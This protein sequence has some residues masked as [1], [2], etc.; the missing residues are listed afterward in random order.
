MQPTLQRSR[1]PRAIAARRAGLLDHVRAC[2]GLTTTQLA[3]A[4]GR[5]RNT[6]Q[7]DMD[8][9]AAAGLVTGW[10]QHV[11][12]LRRAVP[13]WF[14]SG[15]EPGDLDAVRR[16]QVQDYA[17]KAS[18]HTETPGST[19]RLPRNTACAG[20]DP[21]LFFP[22]CK[23]DEAAAK[24][25]CARCPVRADCF[26]GACARGEEYGVWGGENFERD[27]DLPGLP[28]GLGSRRASPARTGE[29]ALA[30]A[31]RIAGLHARHRS[32]S[33][34]AQAAGVNRKTVRFYLDLSEVPASVKALVSAGKLSAADAVQRARKQ[35]AVAS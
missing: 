15:A 28:Q 33:A 2:P 12:E 9:L 21:A 32:V 3:L 26:Q 7:D 31:Q 13:H 10:D 11:D 23:D 1:D 4:S 14:P 20:A 17:A 16:K 35:K 27:R 6:V 5:T 19:I 30:K 34:T 24:A 18:Y 29:K 25:I 8:A 22:E